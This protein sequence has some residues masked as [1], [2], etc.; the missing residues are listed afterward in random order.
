[1]AIRLSGCPFIAPLD[2]DDFFLDG[3]F[4]HMDFAAGN[5]DVIGDNILFVAENGARALVGEPAIPGGGE[6]GGLDLTRF[7]MGN[8]SKPGRPRGEQIGR[9]SCRE[10]VWQYVKISVVAV[11]FKKKNKK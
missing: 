4:A 5:W 6:I 11:A 8:L 3:R 2:A 1:M 10:R 7:V 9:A